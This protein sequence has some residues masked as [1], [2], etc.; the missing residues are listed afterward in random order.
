MSRIASVFA[1]PNHKAL[2]PYVTIG[3]PSIEATLAV[4]PLLADSGCD[5]VELGIPFS[6]PLADGATI[7]KA[8]FKAIQNGVTPE[9]CLEVA[10]K[11]SRKVGVPLVLMTYFNP[12]FNYGIE[13]FGAAC[14]DSGIDGLIIPDLPP[15]ESIDLE[16][17]TQRYGID[18]I[19]LLT[20]SSTEERIRIVAS[21]S[22]GFI[23]LVSVTGVTGVRD[24]LPSGL[25]AFAARVRRIASLPLCVGF[26]ISTCE[27]ARQVARIADGVIIG[28]RLIQL[29]EADN[30][31]MIRLQDFIKEL[32]DAL[33]EAGEIHQSRRIRNLSFGDAD[34]IYEV[35]NQAAPAYKGVIPDD[36]YREPYM[37]SE[38]LHHEMKN[39]T[40]FGWEEKGKI[41]GVMGSQPT[42]DV[43]LIRHAYVLPGYQRKGIGARLLNHLKQ[44]TKTRYLL[45]GT[46]ADAN[47]AIDFYQKHGF[48]LMPN[49]D[50]L[51]GM[52]W[53]IPRR[54]VETSLVLG[55][56][57]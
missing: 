4:V 31:T 22:R 37:S 55:I 46:W 1:Q 19:Y 27:Q 57:M 42:K 15:E 9:L 10:G 26:G 7:Q 21:R 20:P 11:L 32:R 41:V 17:V 53:D 2:I 3:Y 49:K 30:G 56:E 16:A 23:Y 24:R 28:S 40:F 5:I 54:Q 35:I 14:G 8:S 25:E 47:W 39:M 6:D 44:K 43:T 51:L 12:V 45:V 36:C 52:Y 29:L 50:Q 13:E 33:N 48:K 38:E 34:V 18:L